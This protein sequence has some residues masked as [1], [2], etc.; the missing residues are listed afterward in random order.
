VVAVEAGRGLTRDCSSKQLGSRRVQR[1]R[2]GRGWVG[3][4][5]YE[6]DRAERSEWGIFV[7]AR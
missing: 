6:W 7:E 4:T 5:A 1:E 2:E 3:G